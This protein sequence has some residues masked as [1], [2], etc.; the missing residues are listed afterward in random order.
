MLISGSIDAEVLGAP[1]SISAVAPL[2]G[3]AFRL[4]RVLTAIGGWR[5]RP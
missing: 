3:S 5:L 4:A 1:A 2:G